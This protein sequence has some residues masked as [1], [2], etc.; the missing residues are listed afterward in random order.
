MD[1]E[2]ITTR[3]IHH[4]YRRRPYLKKTISDDDFL[5]IAADSNHGAHEI[6][7]NLFPWIQHHVIHYPS[8]SNCHKYLLLAIYTVS[9]LPCL[10]ATDP[11]LFI[12]VHTITPLLKF[13][14]E[15]FTFRFFFFFLH[16]N[17]FCMRFCSRYPGTLGLQ[18]CS[19][20]LQDDKSCVTQWTRNI[21][22]KYSSILYLMC[23]S[24]NV[25]AE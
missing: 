15:I 22:I 5:Y 19:V 4:H 21:E 16:I 11:S 2:A 14:F 12:S 24:W 8:Q 13:L 17:N 20:I 3:L 10:D 25:T 9:A 18:L 1:P 23:R 7:Q 6:P